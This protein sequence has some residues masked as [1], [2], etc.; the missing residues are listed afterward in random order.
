PLAEFI[1]PGHPLLQVVSDVLLER[2]RDLLKRGAVLVD[3]RDDANA[4]R[5]LLCLE[6]AI[7]DAR[8]ERGGVRRVVS[9]QMQFV[10][11]D[12][13]GNCR[14]AG[15]APY[16]D[17]RPLK[18]DEAAAAAELL[19]EPWL[20]KQLEQKAASYAITQLLPRHIMEVRDH[21]LDLIDR[22]RVAV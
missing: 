9:R 5:A 10:E 6:H 3:D 1:S 2:H 13:Q 15:Y 16:L 4:P 12:G 11:M 8:T 22:T 18:D 14:P 21:R 17:C 20:N 19:R 7:Q